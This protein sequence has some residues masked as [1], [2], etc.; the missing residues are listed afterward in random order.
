MD[1]MARVKHNSRMDNSKQNTT[2]NSNIKKHKNLERKGNG[3]EERR[4]AHLMRA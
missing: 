3:R 2:I 1:S 4:I